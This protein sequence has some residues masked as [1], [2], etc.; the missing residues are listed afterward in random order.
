MVN[1]WKLSLYKRIEWKRNNTRIP[2]SSKWGTRE[3]KICWTGAYT[4]LS[5]SRA[6]T[7]KV[8]LTVLWCILGLLLCVTPLFCQFP[9]AL[10]NSEPLRTGASIRGGSLGYL[11]ETPLFSLSLSLHLEPFHTKKI[12]LH[13]YC[14]VCDYFLV[15]QACRYNNRWQIRT[16]KWTLLNTYPWISLPHDFFQ[17]PI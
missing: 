14:I 1:D 17:L 16:L 15:L 13:F 9:K 8:Y 6:Y 5:S 11:G 7:I 10:G 2:L 12:L 4:K 3:T